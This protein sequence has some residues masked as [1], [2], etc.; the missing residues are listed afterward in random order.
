MLN[1]QTVIF[2]DIQILDSVLLCHFFLWHHDLIRTYAEP[3]YTACHLQNSNFRYIFVFFQRRSFLLLSTIAHD[4]S[5]LIKCLF[6]ILKQ[7]YS[8]GCKLLQ[9]IFLILAALDQVIV[10]FDI[11]QIV[12][13]RNRVSL[14]FSGR[15]WYCSRN[16]VSP[17][18]IYM[19]YAVY[20]RVSERWRTIRHKP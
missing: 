15:K 11:V 18:Y 16:P 2:Y 17:Y 8:L 19:E 1:Y 12:H 4:R 3:H 14:Q 10:E 20:S 9:L 6:S 5:N 7:L 13:P